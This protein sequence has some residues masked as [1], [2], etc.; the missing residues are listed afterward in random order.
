MSLSAAPRALRSRPLLRQTMN[1]LVKAIRANDKRMTR[2]HT[3]R[4]D[5][6]PLA[7]WRDLPVALWGRV[8][9][10]ASDTPWIA[11]AAVSFLARV[12]KPDWRVFEFGSGASTPWFAAR[13][14]RLIGLEHDP[15]WH[16]LVSQRLADR[17]IRNCDLRLVELERFTTYMRRYEDET[18][19]LVVVD[20]SEYEPGDR[21]RCVVASAPKVKQGGYLVLDDSDPPPYREA[22]AVLA[23][24]AVRRFVGVKPLPLM[25]VETS[26]YQRPGH[27]RVNQ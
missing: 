18:F 23:G 22:A 20:N 14:G 5:V 17:G 24:W 9:G 10:R 11:P 15:N 3:E 4:G 1:P 16:R 6:M 26:V 19:D 27:Q 7:A 8:T 13:V 25:A 21:L 2:F 12:L